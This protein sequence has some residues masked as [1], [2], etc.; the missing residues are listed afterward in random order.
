M[1]SVTHA[2]RTAVPVASFVP[3]SHRRLL[4][5]VAF[6][7]EQGASSTDH[8]VESWPVPWQISW[9]SHHS[10]KSAVRSRAEIGP[11]RTISI[12]LPGIRTSTAPLSLMITRL[13]PILVTGDS[14][15]YLNMHLC[16]RHMQATPRT[17]S[18]S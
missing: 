7:T 14:L 10:M 16:A 5:P 9:A 1:D 15:T 2:E 11:D 12:H 18:D 13:H 3:C 8:I 4:D 17:E 6:I